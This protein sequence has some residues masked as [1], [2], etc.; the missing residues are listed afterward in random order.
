MT[1]E[2]ALF[3]ATIGLASIATFWV[4]MPEGWKDA[5]DEQRRKLSYHTRKLAYHLRLSTS[6]ERNDFDNLIENM[7]SSV[8]GGVLSDERE[9]LRSSQ[10][11][12]DHLAGEL[13]LARAELSKLEQDDGKGRSKLN[14]K[15]HLLELEHGMAV[16]KLSWQV[17]HAGDEEPVHIPE[18]LSEEL[19][20]VKRLSYLGNQKALFESIKEGEDLSRRA[21]YLKAYLIEAREKGK[22]VG[23]PKRE[24]REAEE[25]L[26]YLRYRKRYFEFEAQDLLKELEGDSKTEEILSLLAKVEP[27]EKL[28]AIRKIR[29]IVEDSV[30]GPGRKANEEKEEEKEETPEIKSTTAKPVPLESMREITRQSQELLEIIDKKIAAAESP[31]ST[32]VREKTPTKKEARRKSESSKPPEVKVRQSVL[33][34]LTDLVLSFDR[35][36][37]RANRRIKAKLDEAIDSADT[38]VN[39]ITKIQAGYAHCLASMKKLEKEEEE[40]RMSGKNRGLAHVMHRRAGLE[41]LRDEIEASLQPLKIKELRANHRI[42]RARIIVSRLQL[43]QSLVLCLPDSQ[44]RSRVDELR[45]ALREMEAYL[46]PHRVGGKDVDL[47]EKLHRLENRTLM[48]YIN[49]AKILRDAFDSN[50][51][52]KLLWKLNP[53]LESFSSHRYYYEAET[54]RWQKISDKAERDAR[55]LAAAVAKERN[56][57]CRSMSEFCK[58]SEKVL[59][60]VIE[61]LSDKESAPTISSSKQEQQGAQEEGD[62][63]P[64][65]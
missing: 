47:A 50:N 37:E 54:A 13:E 29:A 33:D 31:E 21:R 1:P 14:E 43:V 19:L 18:K 53:V 7:V 62:R 42:F 41:S 26:Y 34:S 8:H 57:E 49:L 12:V 24:L 38:L 15:I 30:E 20:Q 4:Y 63:S 55:E 22:P 10:V 40:C 60:A 6:P 3:L 2:T 11:L 17:E 64:L 52:T 5:L 27:G 59:C 58:Q 46:D 45:E 36:I 44:D 65:P 16:E 9:W 61:R 56:S 23:K 39:E 28:N 35:D 48:A 32:M 25:R 51:K